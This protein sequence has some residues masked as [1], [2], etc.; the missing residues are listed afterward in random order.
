MIGPEYRGNPRGIVPLWRARSVTEYNH[1]LLP[2]EPLDLPIVDSQESLLD[3][4]GYLE[5]FDREGAAGDKAEE[6]QHL[7]SPVTAKEDAQEEMLG[8]API[9]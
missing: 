7:T 2:P 6:E 5:R 1:E 4:I 8:D 3:I 9:N